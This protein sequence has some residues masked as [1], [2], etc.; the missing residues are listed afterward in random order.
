MKLNLNRNPLSSCLQV[1]AIAA[2][3]SHLLC[4][5]DW[6][7]LLD[8]L[9]PQL[10]SKDFKSLCMPFPTPSMLP[11]FWWKNRLKRFGLKIR[12]RKFRVETLN[13]KSE[14]L[15]KFKAVK[16]QMLS[17][18]EIL[19]HMGWI[20]DQDSWSPRAGPIL[21]VQESE[22]LNGEIWTVFWTMSTKEP[23]VRPLLDKQPSI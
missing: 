23:L 2:I 9:W 17:H 20:L 18:D 14:K 19:F 11:H 16:M 7:T 5:Y 6:A 13:Y 15:P 21:W 8:C 3:L 1:G 10:A 4:K 12:T 22:F